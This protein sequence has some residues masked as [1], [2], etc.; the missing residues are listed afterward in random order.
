[1]IER[2]A[3]L[4]MHTSPLLQPGEGDAGGMNV[5]VHELSETMSERGIEIDVFTRREN[6]D[7]PDLV[8]VGERYRVHHVDAGPA[9]QLPLS[10]QALFVREFAEG[11]LDFYRGTEPPDMVHSHYW[12]SGWAGLIVKR[13]LGVPLANSFHTL[14][15]V[16]DL[17]RR[18]GEPPESLLRLAAEHEVIEEADCVVASTPLE[19]ED[20]LAHY[21]ADPARLCM[22]PPGVDHDVF[23]PG[24]REE[25]R[26][27]LGLG[28]GPLVLFVGRI[29][30]L[31]GLDVVVEAFRLTHEKLPEARLMVVGGPSGSQ[32]AKEMAALSASI[33]TAGLSAAVD[34]VSPVPHMLL[35][36]YYRAADV[37]HVPSRSES[38]GLVAAEAQSCGLPVVAS[39]VGGLTH[40]VDDGRSG[41]LVEGWEPLDHASAIVRVLDDPGL[42][43]EYSRGALEWSQRFSWDATANRFIELY[44]GAVA[45]ARGG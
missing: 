43:A 7:V 1:M 28:A 35:A 37:L 44:S 33:V 23:S 12:L 38:F 8:V 25:A 16:K 3:Y 21:G 19:S 32:G 20:L 30:P 11:V 15:R 40:A 42:A 45:R 2:L 17:T 34:I 14:G 31:K 6:P 24:S 22:S 29:Q 27:R 26:V 36:D 10:K 9:R 41:I 5:Y 18:D 4:S 39:R 13:G